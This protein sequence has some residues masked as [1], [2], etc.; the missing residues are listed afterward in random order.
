M[1]L[2]GNRA[3]EGKKL[4]GRGF[5]KESDSKRNEFVLKNQRDFWVNGVRDDWER[6][7]SGDQ[8]GKGS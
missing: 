8:F 7:E 1:K 5:G 6:V 4:K 3:V 2:K